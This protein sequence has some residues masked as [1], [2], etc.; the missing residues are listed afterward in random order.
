[1]DEYMF[2][3]NTVSLLDVMSKGSFRWLV[4]DGWL[5]EKEL[6]QIMET[7]GKLEYTKLDNNS[8]LISEKG[9]DV[10]LS[11]REG[12][13]LPELDNIIQAMPTL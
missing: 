2:Y 11:L 13:K 7:L 10:L 9:L 6:E 8:V 5:R 1:M 4:D 12:H 3:K